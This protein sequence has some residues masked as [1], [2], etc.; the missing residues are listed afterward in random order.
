VK[1]TARVYKCYCLEGKKISSFSLR[2]HGW[3]T[4]TYLRQKKSLKEL[5]RWKQ[6]HSNI[7]KFAVDVQ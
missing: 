6:T 3:A 2:A 5:T 7:Q 1:Y 4:V